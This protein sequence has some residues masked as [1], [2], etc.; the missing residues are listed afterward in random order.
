MKGSPFP[1]LSIFPLPPLL[2]QADKSQQAYSEALFIY[3]RDKT[4]AKNQENSEK[5]CPTHRLDP[6]TAAGGTLKK[7]TVS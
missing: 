6:L 4:D 3:L 2:L 5:C 7:V 1:P